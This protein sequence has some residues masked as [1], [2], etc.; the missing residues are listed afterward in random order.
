ML[1]RLLKF[2]RELAQALL[3]ALFAERAL[4]E[5]SPPRVR[6]A[7][8]DGPVRPA[9]ESAA[10]SPLPS[11]VSP[12]LST[13]ALA[14][15][16]EVLR[17]DG[18]YRTAEELA[19]LLRRRGCTVASAHAVREALKTDGARHVEVRL[20]AEPSGRIAEFRARPTA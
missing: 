12:P 5:A 19:V 9:G 7:V 10:P 20:R 16:L 6:L 15:L 11:P 14:D 13:I 4:P 17:G 1:F 2:P 8:P 18:S 3:R